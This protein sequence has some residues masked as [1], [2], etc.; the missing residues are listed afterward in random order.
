MT[1]LDSLNPIGVAYYRCKARLHEKPFAEYH[2]SHSISYVRKGSFGYRVRGESFELVAGSTLV[3]SIG[4][5]YRC[6]H[7]HVCGAECLSIRFA[8]DVA[9]SVGARNGI[10][11]SRALPPLSELMVLGELAQAAW[12]QRTDVGVDEA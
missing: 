12:E 2:D 8:P 4:D 7:E 1:A 6:S 11:Q 3:G 5:E 9:D 10:W